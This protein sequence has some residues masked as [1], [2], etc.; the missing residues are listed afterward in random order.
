MRSQVSGPV[1]GTAISLLCRALGFMHG[2][3]N[4]EGCSYAQLKSATACNVAQASIVSRCSQTHSG[5]TDAI[6]PCPL[7]QSSMRANSPIK[8]ST[9]T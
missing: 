1:S 2:L 7:L 8:V 3:A 6:I 9:A 4:S 5:Y